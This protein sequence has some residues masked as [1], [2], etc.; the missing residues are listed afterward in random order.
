MLAP[1]IGS[2]ANGL[3]NKIGGGS[4]S[5]V[6]DGG[7]GMGGLGQTAGGIIGNMGSNMLGGISNGLTNQVTDKLFGSSAD[8]DKEAMDKLYPGTNSWDRLSAGGGGVTTPAGGSAVQKM[9]MSIPEKVAK[10]QADAQR[11]SAKKQYDAATGKIRLFGQ[12]VN[13]NL[14]EK[15][16]KHFGID[17]SDKPDDKPD[18][19][20]SGVTTPKSPKKEPFEWWKYV[21]PSPMFGD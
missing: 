19:K 14:A 18:D 6:T 10:I 2:M 11:Y 16:L 21:S 13:V 1:F 8:K 7:T 5:G 12:E 4:E 15:I 3:M 9:Q 17:L 20:P